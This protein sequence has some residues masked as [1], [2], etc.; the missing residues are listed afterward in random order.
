MQ[1]QQRRHDLDALRASAML[2][3]ITY[4]VALSF[5]AGF[6]WLV[7]DRRQG[8]GYLLFEYVAHGFRLPLFFLI[9]GFFTAM[10]WRRRGVK[11]LIAHRFRRILLPC[12]LGLITVVPVMFV[13]VGLALFSAAQKRD[14][15]PHVQQYS[16]GNMVRMSSVRLSCPREE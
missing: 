12:L 3:G 7:Q 9:S 4:H 10:L 5:A 1:T 6:P 8:E 14:A 13:V 15:W 2:L 16:G 11:A